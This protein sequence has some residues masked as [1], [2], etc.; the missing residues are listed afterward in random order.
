VIKNCRK[1]AYITGTRADFGL[2]KRCLLE[3][4]HHP[5]LELDV[6]VTGMHL[7]FTHGHTVEEIRETGLTIRSEFPV[8]QEPSTG[9]TMARNLGT[10]VTHFV[11]E[12]SVNSPDMVLLLGDRGEMLAGAIAAIHLNIPVVHIHGGE[13]SGTV[14]EPVRHAISKLSHYHFTST[15]AARTRLIK[16]GERPENIFVTGAPGLDGITDLASEEKDDLCQG[17]GFSKKKPIALMV[18][19]PVL[20]EADTAAEST[21]VIVESLLQESVQTLALM[22]NSDAGSEAVRSVLTQ[23]QEQNDIVVLNHLER[24]HFVAWMKHCDF[25][26]GNSSAGI[27]EAGSFG[28]PVINLGMRQNLRERNANVFDVP[29]E[30]QQIKDAIRHSLSNGKSQASNVYGD[31]TAASVISKLLA[32]VSLSNGVL[33]KVNAY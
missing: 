9:A 28:T 33:N 27:I 29:I 18:F 8:P 23:Y 21:K 22:P 6:L 25:M 2:M 19:H 11:D 5:E 26:I 17:I 12:L 7:S 1:I 30:A 14:D 3:I 13:R 4:T 31:G 16:M 15:E 32:S 24:P 10:M 20:Q